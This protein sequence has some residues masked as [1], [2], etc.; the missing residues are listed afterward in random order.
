MS[1]MGVQTGSVVALEPILDVLPSALVLIEPGTARVVYANQA[2]HRLAGG[3]FPTGAA[4]EEYD[5]VYRC[6]DEHGER[7]PA[8]RMPGVRAARGE[9]FNNFQMD[10]ETPAGLRSVVVAGD[11]IALPDGEQVGVV[12]F[13]DVSELQSARRRSSLLAE[14][15]RLLAHSLDLAETLASVGRLVVPDH[16][17][18][19]FVELLQPDGRIE[20]AVMAHRDPSKHGF[21]AEYDRRYPLDP[22]AP[23]GSAR[24]IRTGEAELMSD[25]PDEFLATVAQDD[26]QLRLLREVGF[27]S[28]M[29]VPL[30]GATGVIGDLALASAESARRYDEEDLASAQ[31]LADRCALAIEKARLYEELRAAE[32]DCA[33]I[34][35]RAARR[36][37]AAWRTR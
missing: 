10:W 9:R 6:F 27:R 28:A 4:A 20:R 7:I 19:C 23:A 17:D 29:I 26:E 3:T 31:E 16:A 5:A 12:T 21:V 1:P 18:W 33:A 8:D 2:A 35:R 25:I 34:A 15:G 24:V 22:D 13:E 36:S 37:S 14:G 32:A 30:R 11:V